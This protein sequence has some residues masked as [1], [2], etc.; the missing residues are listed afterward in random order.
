MP[1]APFIAPTRDQGQRVGRLKQGATLFFTVPGATDQAAS[2]TLPA[3]GRDYYAP[4]YTPAPLVVDQIACEVTTL[5]AAKNV[6]IGLYRADTN[7]QPIGAPLADSGDL[8]VATTGVKTYTPTNPLFL[9]RGLYVSIF[10]TNAAGTLNLRVYRAFGVAIQAAGGN[11]V[12]QMFIDRAYAAFP[13]PGTAHTG[14]TTAN[15]QTIE[16]VV[17]YR[18]S[19]P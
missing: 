4:W 15:V 14:T 16:H 2:T 18:V 17:I 10:N 12:S 8:S 19:T 7:W 3:G 1:T 11:P 9:G 13:T 6:R 5:E